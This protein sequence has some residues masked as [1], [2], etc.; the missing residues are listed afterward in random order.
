MKVATAVKYEVYFFPFVDKKTTTTKFEQ[1]I[2]FTISYSP[3]ENGHNA[4]NN[5]IH[6]RKKETPN[7][8]WICWICCMHNIDCSVNSIFADIN[9]VVIASCE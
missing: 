8:F 7:W 9:G 4:H 5:P 6:E 2:R 3:V 1:S